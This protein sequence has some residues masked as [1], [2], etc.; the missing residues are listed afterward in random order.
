MSAVARCT[1][2]S[3][4]TSHWHR[5]STPPISIDGARAKCW[6]VERQSNTNRSFPLFFA[7]Q[8]GVTNPFR[9]RE[10]P[11]MFACLSRRRK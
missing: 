7:T 5:A 3:G 11:R 8:N 2:A 1:S 10:M 4:A 9:L 6:L